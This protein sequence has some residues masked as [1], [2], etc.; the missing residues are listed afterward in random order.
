ML[1]A[2]EACFKGEL[3]SMLTLSFG[4]LGAAAG[5]ERKKRGD[6]DVTF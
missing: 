2:M 5:D 6:E 4:E 3:M 1:P